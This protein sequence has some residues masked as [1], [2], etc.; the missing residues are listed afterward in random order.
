MRRLPSLQLI[1]PLDHFDPLHLPHLSRP[2]SNLYS[3]S[4]PQPKPS[5]ARQIRSDNFYQSRRVKGGSWNGMGWGGGIAESFLR[6]IEGGGEGKGE[7]GGMRDRDRGVF[8]EHPRT[9]LF[10]GGGLV[11]F[12]LF[13][14]FLPISEN[15]KD[16]MVYFRESHRIDLIE[17]E[18]SYDKGRSSITAQRITTA[19]SRIQ[20]HKNLKI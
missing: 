1:S 15:K 20:D 14:S 5:H 8:I 7:R 12:S 2:H 4:L 9:F 17:W 10:H 6:L 13:S 16:S 18:K 11:E 19:R 3:G